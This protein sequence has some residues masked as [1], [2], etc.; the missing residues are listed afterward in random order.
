M[1][2]CQ[3]VHEGVGARAGRVSDGLVHA[4]VCVCLAVV[5][6]LCQLQQHETGN[7]DAGDMVW[8]G[9]R[10]LLQLPQGQRL[11]AQH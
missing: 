4:Y 6:S 1:R 11:T 9:V 8:A 3:M 5:R 10:R 7:G 2:T